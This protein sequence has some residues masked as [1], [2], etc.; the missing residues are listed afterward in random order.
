[1]MNKSEVSARIATA[2]GLRTKSVMCTLTTPGIM[3]DQWTSIYDDLP[4]SSFPPNFFTNS[5][6]ADALRNWLDTNNYGLSEWNTVG[7]EVFSA[8]VKPGHD[9]RALFVECSSSRKYSLAVAADAAIQE[10][11]R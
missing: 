11:T 7:G 2:M 3:V 10:T 1:M 8:W 6:A 5:D 9:C 4:P